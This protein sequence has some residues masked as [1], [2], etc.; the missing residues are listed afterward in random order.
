MFAPP[1][2]GQATTWVCTPGTAMKGL[3]QYGHANGCGSKVGVGCGV[4][5]K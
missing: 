2:V 5:H 1:Q 4:L 3:V